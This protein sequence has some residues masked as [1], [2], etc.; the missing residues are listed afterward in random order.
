M[1][2]ISFYRKETGLFTGQR[3]SGPE[4]AIAKNTPDGCDFKS[5]SIDHEAR[6]VDL[7]TGEVVAYQPEAP[8]TDHVWNG[9]TERWELSAAA[10]A[11]EMADLQAR[12]ALAQQD[13]KSVRAMREVLL[14]TLPAD[15]PLRARLAAIED[16]CVVHR[17]NLRK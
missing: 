15:S 3:F 14:E 6:R 7:K 11:V 8:S 12:A 5:G 1:P 4:H 9:T 16:D 17:G 2:S 10:Q 13:G